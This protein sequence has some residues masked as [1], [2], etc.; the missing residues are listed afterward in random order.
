MT[1][2][3]LLI[4]RTF[5]KNPAL[6][7]IFLTKFL[8]VR[9]ELVKD[10]IRVMPIIAPVMKRHRNEYVTT[11]LQWFGDFKTPIEDLAVMCQV[12]DKWVFSSS[13]AET[14]HF[15]NLLLS[16][17][18]AKVSTEHL[19]FYFTSLKQVF[20]KKSKP[21]HYAPRNH[22]L[23]LAKSTLN[24]DTLQYL[25]K[26]YQIS[27]SEENDLGENAFH[28]FFSSPI[29]NPDSV[30]MLHSL[31]VNIHHE[32]KAGITPL[33]YILQNLSSYCTNIYHRL[34]LRNEIL[35]VT[36][37]LFSDEYRVNLTN[38]TRAL[39]QSWNPKINADNMRSRTPR[40]FYII[41]TEYK[42]QL[43]EAKLPLDTLLKFKGEYFC[44]KYPFAH[45]VQ[46]I[47]QLFNNN[48]E[49]SPQQQSL[50]PM[51][52]TL[53]ELIKIVDQHGNSILHL[54]V[55][56]INGK[57]ACL[58]HHLSIF[59]IEWPQ[60]TEHVNHKGEAPIHLFAKELYCKEPLV[61]WSR[62]VKQ[63]DWNVQE[64]ETGD[65]VLHCLIK[66]L[67]KHVAAKRYSHDIEALCETAT[68][69]ARRT[70]IELVNK[71]GKTARQELAEGLKQVAAKKLARMKLVRK[72]L[73]KLEKQQQKYTPCTKCNA[74]VVDLTMH[75]NKVHNK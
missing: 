3:Q 33:F 57:I 71:K 6:L 60:I 47:S 58:E 41:L 40:M 19:D 35:V 42:K 65:S 55:P 17:L 21:S 73:K 24:L 64:I 70:S 12:L 20:L 27:S 45:I 51:G 56:L 1:C 4:F 30:P 61:H 29:S 25:M 11:L 32:N 67:L 62:L 13:A 52:P 75:C 2:F 63:Q 10:P 39:Y 9:A 14:T 16:N 69:V 66:T 34:H 68:F 48:N 26:K 22:F 36:K 28:S 50:T 46:I 8:F 49:S 31:G 72:L 37:Y 43:L 5:C 53:N 38:Y 18:S 59:Q 7:F 44:H 54:L 74:Y 15:F 23:Y